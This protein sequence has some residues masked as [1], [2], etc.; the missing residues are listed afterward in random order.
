MAKQYENETYIE[1]FERKLGNVDRYPKMTVEQ[2]GRKVRK[3]HRDLAAT[4]LYL[5]RDPDSEAGNLMLN[6]IEPHYEAALKE[7]RGR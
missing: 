2:L 4:V 5:R 6:K 1:W 7:L 3:L